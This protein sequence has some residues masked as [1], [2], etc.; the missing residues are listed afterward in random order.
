MPLFQLKVPLIQNI[1]SKEIKTSIT[2]NSKQFKKY[3]IV[4]NNN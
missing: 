1:R 3:Q 2:N 4:K